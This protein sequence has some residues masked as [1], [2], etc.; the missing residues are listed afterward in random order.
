M[1][2]LILPSFI[3]WQQETRLEDYRNYLNLKDEVDA[4][5]DELMRECLCVQKVCIDVDTQHVQTLQS[6]PQLLIALQQFLDV[7][8]A[9]VT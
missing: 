6:A 1:H 2:S 3:F 8:T 5:Q 4:H 9:Y 7:K